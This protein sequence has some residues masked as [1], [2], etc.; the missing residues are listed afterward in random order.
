L[1]QG[2]TIENPQSVIIGEKVI[3]E[4]DVEISANTIIRGET[5]IKEASLIGP[6][7]LI[8]D[9]NIGEKT[10][11]KGYNIVVKQTLSDGQILDFQEKL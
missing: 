3:I 11:L 9:A 4:K 6:N 1:N 7:S 5:L 2:V 10:I 8:I